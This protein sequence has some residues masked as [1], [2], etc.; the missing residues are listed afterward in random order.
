MESNINKWILFDKQN[1][2]HLYDRN[3]TKWLTVPRD[4][5]G[6]FVLPLRKPFDSEKDSRFIIHAHRTPFGPNA[7]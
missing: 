1:A 6:T 4:S 3:E 2:C 5:R 7:N